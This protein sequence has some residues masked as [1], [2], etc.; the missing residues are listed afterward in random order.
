MLTATH[1]IVLAMYMLAVL[2]IGFCFMRQKDTHDFFVAGRSFHWG[3]VALSVMA[4]KLR[5]GC[6]IVDQ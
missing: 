6:R 4:S 2:A 1:L 5:S 3:P